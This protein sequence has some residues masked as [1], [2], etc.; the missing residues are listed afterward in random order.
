MTATVTVFDPAKYKETTRA[1]AGRRR[2]LVSLGAD[3]QCV[4]WPSH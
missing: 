1:M 4:A 2:S 3:A